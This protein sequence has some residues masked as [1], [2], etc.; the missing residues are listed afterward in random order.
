MPHIGLNSRNHAKGAA[1]QIKDSKVPS[2]DPIVSTWHWINGVASGISHF[3][4]HTLADFGRAILFHLEHIVATF[5][6][7]IDATKRIIFWWEY[8]VW[9]M[10]QGWVTKQMAKVRALIRRETA[11]LIRLIYVATRTVLALALNAVRQERHDRKVAVGRAEARAR[12]EVRALHGVVEREAAS[13]YRVSRDDRASLIVRL[14]DYAVIRNPEVKALV[15]KLVTGLLDL[16]SIDD[17]ILRIVLGFV[18][19]H[20][21]DRL[22]IDKAVGILVQDLLTPLLGKPKPGDL[23][24]VIMDLSERMLALEKFAATFMEDG[25]AQVEQAGKEWRNIT[26]VISNAAIVAFTVQAV[27]APE[28]WAKEIDGT[29]GRAV[30]DVILGAERLF[31]G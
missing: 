20:I 2:S 14:L 23:H 25:G 11:Y 7:E 19:K 29:V 15:G 22:G 28:K 12:A 6:E 9:H 30:N 24:D 3:L 13:G 4:G 18:I 17:P 5:Q 1:K 31:K 16:L 8:A 26:S 10:I 27:V 21:I